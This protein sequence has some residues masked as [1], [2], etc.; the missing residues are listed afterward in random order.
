MAAEAITHG[1]TVRADIEHVE[2]SR[3]ADPARELAFFC[4]MRGLKVKEIVRPGDGQPLPA[5]VV[6]HG[7]T[8]E[9]EGFYDIRN[10]LIA[11]NGRIEVTVDDRSEVV[12]VR[13]VLSSFSY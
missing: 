1:E 13:E 12:P 3:K 2:V 9:R 8:V 7:L 5:E 10:A 11:S 6:L 4:R